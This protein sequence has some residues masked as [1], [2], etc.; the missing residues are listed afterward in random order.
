MT[1]HRIFTLVHHYILALYDTI[2]CKKSVV[3]VGDL[4]MQRSSAAF[5]Q[6]ILSSRY[7]DIRSY[8]EKEDYSFSVQKMLAKYKY[9]DRYGKDYRH[10]IM[11]KH[12]ANLIDS[13]IKN[14]YD[15]KS[16]IEVDKE[17]TLTDGTHRVA[18][19]IYCQHWDLHAKIVR[20][21]S[22]YPHNI[23][24]YYNLGVKTDLL[25]I[26]NNQTKE[27][28][29]ILIENG[30]TFGCLIYHIEESTKN[31]LLS[32]LNNL[33]EIKRIEKFSLPKGTATSM[34]AT[35]NVPIIGYYILFTLIDP[36]YKY[37]NTELVSS[38]SNKIELLLRKRYSSKAKIIILNN[39]IKGKETFDEL[40]GYF[41]K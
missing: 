27:I 19:A 12:F 15:K 29:G 14:G 28:Q 35:S 1:Y 33:C 3:S 13:F 17:G 34:F 21:K 9:G 7:L 30:V 18:M 24:Y 25:E 2:T 8:I 11:S 38:R 20:R 39:C 22:K 6:F 10:N 26:I 4:F 23:D 41:V 37:K 36:E 16:I 31:N 5:V 40:Q 32:D